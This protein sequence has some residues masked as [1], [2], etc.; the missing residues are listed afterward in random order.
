[1]TLAPLGLNSPIVTAYPPTSSRWEATAGPDAIATIAETADRLGYSH[2]SC[3][4]HTAVPVS[5]AAERGGTYWD[6]LATLSFVAARTRRIRL[7]TKVLVLGYHHPL[8]I[9]KRYGTLDRLSGG[10]VS[11][12]LGVG[13]LDDEFRL[14]GASFADRGRRADEAIDAIRSAW[15]HP[16]PTHRGTYFSYDEVEVSPAA[17]SEHVPL[18]IGGR[19]ERSLDRAIARGD[20]WMPFA[21]SADR[22]ATMLDRRDLRPGF[23]VV[24]TTPP[25]DPLAE[26]D[27]AAAEIRRLL[28][29]GATEVSVTV[30]A[31]ELSHYLDQLE[32]LATVSPR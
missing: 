27:A 26:P 11:L 6:P 16:R 14:L 24:L 18:Y 10:R 12:G 17:L 31:G 9:V 20:G 22:I 30:R 1:M 15:G 3:A 25:L 4:E 28:D 13:S 5:L 7:L 32:A 19:S 29:V 2:F 21:L 23:A 8:E